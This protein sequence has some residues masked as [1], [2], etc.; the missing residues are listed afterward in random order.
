MPLS[1]PFEICYSDSPSMSYC[2]PY[3]AHIDAKGKLKATSSTLYASLALYPSLVEAL[4]YQNFT[5][6][7]IAYVIQQACLHMHAPNEDHILYLKRILHYNMLRYPSC[8]L[9]FSFGIR[10]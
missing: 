2:K 1:L 7:D 8:I 6:A 9:S 10:I 5:R 3:V 4:Q